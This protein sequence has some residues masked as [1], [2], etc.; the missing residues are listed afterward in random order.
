MSV[1]ILPAPLQ[2]LPL[3]GPF[4]CTR[5]VVPR[6]VHKSVIRSHGPIAML[7]A[8]LSFGAITSFLGCTGSNNNRGG[9]SATIRY[10]QVGADWLPIANLTP[11]SRRLTDETSNK[12]L[13]N[14]CPH[15]H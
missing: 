1:A 13:W 4:V 6:K 12:N 9:G 2:V 5:R 8:I 3:S 15:Q 14:Q 7:L 11:R 10:Y